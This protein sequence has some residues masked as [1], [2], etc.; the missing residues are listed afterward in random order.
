MNS[1]GFFTFSIESQYLL[2]DEDSS[3]INFC[4][5]VILQAISVRYGLYMGA[6]CTPFVLILM[7]LFG[8]FFPS[9]VP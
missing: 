9:F 4:V 8:K 2:F 3:T 1:E 7:F 5:Q 6:T